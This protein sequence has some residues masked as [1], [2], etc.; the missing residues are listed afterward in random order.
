MRADG[1]ILDFLTYRVFIAGET[2]P[3]VEML[4]DYG[5]YHWPTPVPKAL[6]G[7]FWHLAGAHQDAP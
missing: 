7:T 1:R 3:A 5:S 4:R 6:K 2:G